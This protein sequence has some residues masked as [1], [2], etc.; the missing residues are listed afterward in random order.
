MLGNKTLAPLEELE[1]IFQPV[2]QN[3]RTYIF[4]II[5]SMI[6]NIYQE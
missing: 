5:L 2:F 6:N 4:I 1:Q 3:A